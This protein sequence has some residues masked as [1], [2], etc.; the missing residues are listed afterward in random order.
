MEL[1]V[2]SPQ[3]KHVQFVTILFSSSFNALCQLKNQ[4]RLYKNF[5]TVS[6]VSAVLQLVSVET[7]SLKVMLLQNSKKG[8]NKPSV[9]KAKQ[10]SKTNKL[11]ETFFFFFTF[12]CIVIIDTPSSKHRQP[13]VSCSSTPQWVGCLLRGSPLCTLKRSCTNEV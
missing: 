5:N 10:W 9:L 2:F 11:E 4:H 12:L 1:K 6:S 3:L 8:K 13:V 7:N